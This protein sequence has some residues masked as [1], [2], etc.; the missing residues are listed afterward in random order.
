MSGENM[1]QIQ[2][3]KASNE[4]TLKP[5]EGPIELPRQN[6]KENLTEYVRHISYLQDQ[7]HRREGNSV[8]NAT[9]SSGI[10]SHWQS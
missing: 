10:S 5:P 7:D 3:K 1:R 8:R 2:C 6:P 9:V 4:A